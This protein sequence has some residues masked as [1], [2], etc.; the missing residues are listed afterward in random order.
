MVAGIVATLAYAPAA[1]AVALA[2]KVCGFSLHTVVTFGGAL[3]TFTGMFAWW[4]IAF[5]AACAYALFAFPWKEE[6]LAWPPK[7]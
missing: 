4:L 2:A 5:A 1:L 7:K 6:V 3:G